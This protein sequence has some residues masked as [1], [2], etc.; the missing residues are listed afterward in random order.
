MLYHELRRLTSTN[1]NSLIGQNIMVMI[2][3]ISN[4]KFKT[5][6]IL[7]VNYKIGFI[8]IIL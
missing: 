1:V 4:N 8:L 2:N 7:Y 5:L 6:K 3:N